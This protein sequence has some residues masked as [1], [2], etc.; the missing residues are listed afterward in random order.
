M[1]PEPM[2]VVYG[3]HAGDGRIRY[4]GKTKRGCT[5]RLR[6][7]LKH[8]RRGDNRHSTIWIRSVGFENVRIEILEQTSLENLSNCEIAWIA[9]LRAAGCALTN[10]TSGGDGQSGMSPSPEHRMAI[11]KAH[12]GKT[13]PQD[14][15]DRQRVSRAAGM[16]WEWTIEQRQR[17]SLSA[18]LRFASEEAPMK[19]RKRTPENVAQMRATSTARL[20]SGNVSAA[21]LSPSKVVDMRRLHKEGRTIVE[22]SGAFGVC[23]E[24]ASKAVRGL[25]W[26]Q[27]GEAA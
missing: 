10:H 6:E 27:V 5:Q 7:H 2:S 18:L 3:L 4:V 23:A 9:K 20:M 26:T 8:A 1:S 22:I 16:G 21:K 24:T 11:S 14:V 13:V 15:I 19:G 25:T 12:R 17:A